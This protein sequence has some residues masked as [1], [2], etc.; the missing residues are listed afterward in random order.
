MSPSTLP[1]GVDHPTVPASAGPGPGPRTAFVLSGGASLG[2]MQ[3][4]ALWALYE[5]GLRPDLLI[6]ASVGALNAAFVASRPQT[7]ATARALARVWQDMRR[8]DV[9][10]V[11]LP[12]LLRGAS[13]RSDHLVPDDGLRRIVRRHVEFSDLRDA[14]IPLHVQTFDL[15]TA[16]EVLLSE[17][18]AHEALLAAAAIP[19]VLPPV[20]WRPGTPDERLLVDGGVVNNTPISHAVALGAERIYVLPTQDGPRPLSAAPASALDLAIHGLSL[21]VGTRWRHDIEYYRGITEVIVLPAPNSGA[22]QP[23][24]FDQAHRLIDGSLRATREALATADRTAD[25]LR[26]T[27]EAS[28]QPRWRGRGLR[29]R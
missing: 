17:G 8:E 23:T 10:P 16:H 24:D 13:G 29:R 5:Q 6:G 12:A 27:G 7:P 26:L 11:S 3:V 22:V 9:F 18:P 1:P 21:L 28:P 14:P 25:P 4:G 2:A 15:R 20:Q 19:G